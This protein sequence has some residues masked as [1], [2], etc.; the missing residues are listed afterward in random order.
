MYKIVKLRELSGLVP[1]SSKRFSKAFGIKEKIYRE[2]MI[3]MLKEL[4]P[5]PQWYIVWDG[6][7]V[8][9]GMGVIENDGHDRPDLTPNVCAVFTDEEHRGKGLARALMET[10]CED[11]AALGFD[12]LYLTTNHTDFYERLGWEFLCMVNDKDGPARMYVHH[13]PKPEEPEVP[14]EDQPE[15]GEEAPEQPEN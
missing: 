14:G 5:I 15:A 2:S 1:R 3:D 13:Q 4:G 7:A 11:M 10:V 6:T 8:V 12:T 9:A